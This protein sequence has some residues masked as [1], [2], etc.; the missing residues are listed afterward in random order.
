MYVYVDTL[1]ALNWIMNVVILLGTSK[2]TGVTP[3]LARISLSA[4]LGALASL[5][6]FLPYGIFMRWP[7]VKVLVSLI[8]VAIA[9]QPLPWRRWPVIL[10]IFYLISFMLGGLV[11]A[12][13]YF[14]DTSTYITNGVFTM[15]H[16]SWITL[17]SAAV[18]LCCLGHWAWGKLASRR[19]Q[20][21]F[22]MPIRIYLHGKN[23]RILALM[24]SGNCLKDP[25]S[26]M[27]VVI[28]EYTSLKPVLPADVCS[29]FD[30][31]AE[32]N[33]LELLHKLP[34][35]WVSRLHIV[36]YSSLGRKGGLV[37]GFRPD[38]LTIEEQGGEAAQCTSVIIGIY[39]R[40]LASQGDYSAL[41]HPELVHGTINC[42]KEA[43]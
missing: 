27:P 5:V 30:E 13:L 42:N 19:W 10:S 15:Q 7:W 21:K 33:W 22:I 6:M 9:F 2:M 40:K 12:M 24:D 35:E 26:H 28:A 8:M 23:V 1:V 14:M 25:I 4:G 29:F 36:P 18:I 16:A 39:N 11:L 31:T 37:I 17:V 32:D 34:Y 20:P 41:L 43:S 38:Y 3:R